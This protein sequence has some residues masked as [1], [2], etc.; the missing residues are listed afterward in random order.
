MEITQ[1]VTESPY[2]QKIVKEVS[3]QAVRLWADGQ[4]CIRVVCVCDRSTRVPPSTV[5]A[6]PLQA[7]FE[8]AGY[9][10]KGPFR[11]SIKKLSSQVKARHLAVR[12]KRV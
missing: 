7:V 5:V 3:R 6:S 4:A 10:S 1:S 9:N 8:Q 11:F 12:D 2:F